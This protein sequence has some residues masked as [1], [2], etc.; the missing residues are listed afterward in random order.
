MDEVEV[1]ADPVAATVALDPVRS[2]L[3]AELS[4]P[5]SAAALAVRLGIARQKLNYHLRELEKHGLVRVVEERKWGGLTERRLVASAASFVI[6]PD[7]MG[8]VGSDPGRGGDTLSASYLIALAARVIREVGDL[9]RRAR[10]AGRAAPTLSIDTAVRFKSPDDR[11]A[12]ASDLTR[13]VTDLVARYH[14]EAAADGRSYRIVI[15]GHPL[16]QQAQGK[17]PSCQ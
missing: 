16:P 1:I 3:L 4:Q 9:V 13:A 15:V 10:A 14:D 2:R 12:F 11:A 8:Q 6:S 7:A 17:E 5:A